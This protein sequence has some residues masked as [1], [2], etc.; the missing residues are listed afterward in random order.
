MNYPM[1]G[2]KLC[3]T[4]QVSITVF[5][6]NLR[7][8]MDYAFS[9]HIRLNEELS[10]TQNSLNQIKAFP[11]PT[12]DILTLECGDITPQE[13]QIIDASGRIVH[14]L[15]LDTNSLNHLEVPQ[16]QELKTGLYFVKLISTDHESFTVKILKK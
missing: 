11:N 9:L 10:I 12:S 7:D 6:S 3:S 1:E 14:Q 13:I 5:I 4:F 2:Q 16:F 8:K 15:F